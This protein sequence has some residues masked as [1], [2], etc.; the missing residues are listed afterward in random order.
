MSTAYESGVELD[1]RELAPSSL[2]I[3]S[4]KLAQLDNSPNSLAVENGH[5][6]L[7]PFIKNPERTVNYPLIGA[8]IENNKGSIRQYRFYLNSTIEDGAEEFID[9]I[10]PLPPQESHIGIYQKERLLYVIG[11]MGLIRTTNAERHQKQESWYIVRG[12]KTETKDNRSYQQHVLF[13]KAEPV[14]FLGSISLETAAL[15]KAKKADF[16][17]SINSS[18]MPAWLTGSLISPE[19]WS[20]TTTTTSKKYIFEPRIKPGQVLVGQLEDETILM[21]GKIRYMAINNLD[22]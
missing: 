1:H 5:I 22:R 13:G 19:E 3:I 18:F 9:Q 7:E 6:L 20:K 17:K 21:L 14:K 4:P 11:S 2:D 10:G 8:E 15:Y 16:A 12:E